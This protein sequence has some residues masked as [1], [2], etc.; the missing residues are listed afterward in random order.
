VRRKR[1]DGQGTTTRLQA[2]TG[3][4]FILIW[5]TWMAK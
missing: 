3:I 2:T 4:G 1:L 5:L